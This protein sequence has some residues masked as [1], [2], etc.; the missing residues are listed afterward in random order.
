M[1]ATTSEMQLQEQKVNGKIHYHSSLDIHVPVFKTLGGSEDRMIVL[2][3][4][5]ETT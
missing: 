5:I 3:K 1:Q 2:L 4:L